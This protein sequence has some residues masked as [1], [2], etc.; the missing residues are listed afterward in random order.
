MQIQ[1]FVI[2]LALVYGTPAFSQS[3]TIVCDNYP[4]YQIAKT[5]TVEGFSTRIVQTILQE[6]DVEIK[7]LEIFPWK[8]ALLLIEQGQVDALFSANYTEDRAVYAA[9]PSEPLVQTPWV[10][11]ARTEDTTEYD[12]LDDL[13][14][15]T[16]GVVRGY[17]YTTELWNHLKARN[18]YEEATD[19]DTNFRK[20]AAGRIRY[21]VAELGNGYQIINDLHLKQIAPITAHPVK[22]DGLYIIFN[23]RTV[24]QSLVDTFSRKL[25]KFRQTEAYRELWRQYF[26]H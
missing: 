5:E 9:Y 24:P 21:V 23:K 6:M 8:R 18:N 16:V 19:D 20:L 7:S 12:S 15:G 22:I 26:V 1:T 2:I 17:S 11:W 14:D 25:K 3:L 13:N 4:P 10:I